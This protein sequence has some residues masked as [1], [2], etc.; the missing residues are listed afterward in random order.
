MI[1]ATKQAAQP[2]GYDF[3]TP[4]AS[5]RASAL[6]HAPASRPSSIVWVAVK[7]LKLSYHNGY[8]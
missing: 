7:E 1:G 6:R 4:R 8:I 3:E 5:H 2:R